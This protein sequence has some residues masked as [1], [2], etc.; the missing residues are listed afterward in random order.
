[1]TGELHSHPLDRR[2]EQVHGTFG[3]E[4][5]VLVI[6]RTITSTTRLLEALR[7]FRDDFRVDLVHTINDTSP[8]SRG[9]R[10]LLDR[11]EVERIVPWHRASEVPYA[12]ALSASENVDFAAFTGRTVVLPHGIGFNKFVPDPSTGGTRLA[13]LP[14][15]EAL[16]S[17]RVLLT[18]A[19]E[20]QRAQLEELH[21]G[22]GAH[23]R[24]VGDP[25]YD[26][27]RASLPLREHYR[28]ELGTGGRRLVLLSSTWRPQSL[29][30]T[31]PELARRLV[32]ALPADSYQVA[33]CVHPNVWSHY[34]RD[35]VRSWHASAI[36]GGLVLLPPERGWQAALVAASLVLGDHGSIPLLAAGIGTPLLLAAFG[37]EHVPGTPV[38]RLG[39]AAGHLDPRGDLRGQ[40]DRAIAE[41]DPGRCADTGLF[42]HAGDSTRLL[43]ELLYRE[44]GLD[45][46]DT[47][48]PL[49]RPPEPRP[50]LPEVTSFEVFAELG[51][52]GVRMVRYP[53]A[54]RPA[55][56]GG[57]HPR[58]D[59]PRTA[60]HLAVREDEPHLIRV[61]SATVLVR[62]AVTDEAGALSWAGRMLREFPGVRLAA[63]ATSTGCAAAFRSGRKVRAASAADPMRTASALF[64]LLHDGFAA[65][66]HAVRCG[67][68]E[69]SVDVTDLG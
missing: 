9:V 20:S 54:A 55:G 50:Q 49:L 15:A 10:E 66:E 68:A 57:E 43:R 21:P 12:L 22:V 51:S 34:G 60:R 40:V 32:A 27:L 46:P 17:G 45:V 65:G 37:D 30:G 59:S 23:T 7:F 62:G 44:L 14:R 35:R 25:T 61:Q 47:E 52:S 41:H 29:A 4:R 38:A 16:R 5:T 69:F 13:G 3:C 31:S 39:C 67:P 8:H 2:D 1:M 18:L 56:A 63:A 48:P 24:V 36:E 42:A 6:A 26:Q 19:N 28:R 33:M 64:A 11:A 53:A 58:P